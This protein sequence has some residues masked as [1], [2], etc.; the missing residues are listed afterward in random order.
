MFCLL[1]VL[2]PQNKLEIFANIGKRRSVR[3][4]VRV[5]VHVK[6]TVPAHCIKWKWCEPDTSHRQIFVVFLYSHESDL[7]SETETEQ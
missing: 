6:S 1:L 5:R 7:P 4:R 3:V 2:G